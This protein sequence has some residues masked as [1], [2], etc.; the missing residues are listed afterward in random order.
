MPTNWAVLSME[1]I[2]W[3]N[4]KEKKERDK[5]WKSVYK[6]IKPL[7]NFTYKFLEL[8]L[9]RFKT[10]SGKDRLAMSAI[11][12]KKPDSFATKLLLLGDEH[13]NRLEKKFRDS[14]TLSVFQLINDL[15]GT[16]LVFYFERDI[17][18][19]VLYWL[20]YPVFIPVE[21]VDWTQDVSGFDKD[22]ISWWTEG[23]KEKRSGYESLHFIIRFDT[24][25]LKAR[26]G[27][28]C[29][30]SRRSAA[31][32]KQWKELRRELHAPVFLENLKHVHF[33]VQCRTILEHTWAEVEHRSN[34]SITKAG[35]ASGVPDSALSLKKF[36]CYKAIL[37]SAQIFQNTLRSG[38]TRWDEKRDYIISR[39]THCELGHRAS[40]WEQNREQHK[41]IL[42]LQ[43]QF[44]NAHEKV[45]SWKGIFT[46]IVKLF[47]SLP[48]D[49]Q[50]LS[51]KLPINAYGKA[52]LLYLYLGFVLAY[53]PHAGKGKQTAG[54]CRRFMKKASEYFLKKQFPQGTRPE[55]P[56]A[57]TAIRIYE[58][59]RL[60]DEFHARKD[61]GKAYKKSLFYDSLVSVRAASV[62]YRHF[63]SFRR[64]TQ[65][66]QEAFE[67]AGELPKAFQNTIILTKAYTGKRIA[68]NLW[69]A[70]N[71]DGHRPEDL[72]EA[73]RTAYQAY[74]ALISLGSNS[75]G[76][77]SLGSNSLGSKKSAE[78]EA[79]LNEMRQTLPGLVLTIELARARQKLRIPTVFGADGKTLWLAIAEVKRSI[80]KF[81]E[82]L[83]E[84]YK[85]ME[86]DSGIATKSLRQQ[87][88]AI[89]TACLAHQMASKNDFE[90]ARKIL[91]SARR[92]IRNARNKVTD[93]VEKNRGG[94]IPFHE[95]VAIDVEEFIYALS[96]DDLIE[97]KKT[98]VK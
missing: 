60:L 61:K 77:N 98:G 26:I 31:E 92:S 33:E 82:V 44:K 11:R 85:S 53:C 62:Y 63:G 57:A 95:D 68:E 42:G 59:V 49:K 66:Y 45:N 29:N 5:R 72:R 97:A 80:T 21:I 2:Q 69:T 67:M 56:T 35:L 96:I 93:K 51:T 81:N 34:Y 54:V 12:V 24:D 47:E 14:P 40:F 75:L 25:M 19:A 32:K 64:S 10:Q 1:D 58:T 46:E 74:S 55:V 15:I 94:A 39:N 83:V 84:R 17:Q 76:S 28:A 18:D 30:D 8:D 27:L 7:V 78:Q 4:A 13:K 16:R 88:L 41:S 65:L 9:N 23:G 50:Q 89:W 90:S 37:R 22:G 43:E 20:S 86:N 6:D 36:R 38:F 48:T 71:L 3:K 52:R 73:C 79:K 70:Y 87:G 91:Q